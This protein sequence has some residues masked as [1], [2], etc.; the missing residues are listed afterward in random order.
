MNDD[1]YMVV[2]KAEY[3]ELVEKA[4]RIAVIQRLVD[5]GEYVG[6]KDIYSVLGIKV[7]AKV[8]GNG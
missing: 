4:E 6:H 2:T 1:N 3:T 7:P 8:A 5:S